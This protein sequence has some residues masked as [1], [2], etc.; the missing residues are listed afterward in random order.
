MKRHFI[1]RN[2]SK[3]IFLSNNTD[4]FPFGDEAYYLYL[5]FP[6]MTGF[7]STQGHKFTMYPEQLDRPYHEDAEYIWYRY[8][9]KDLREDDMILIFSRLPPT[10]D[11]ENDRRI[12]YLTGESEAD[13][14]GYMKVE[15]RAMGYEMIIEWQS[16]TEFLV[17]TIR[18]PYGGP[19]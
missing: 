8:Y 18:V 17:E 4:N 10:I 19:N 11:F 16:I 1:S 2:S 3:S 14:T 12:Y 6:I 9:D 13:V 15:Y 5:N 7:T